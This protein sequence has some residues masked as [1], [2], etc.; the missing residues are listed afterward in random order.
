M[1]HGGCSR[2]MWAQRLWRHAG[3]QDG[4]GYDDSGAGVSRDDQRAGAPQEAGAAAQGARELIDA[5]VRRQHHRQEGDDN[6][7][8]R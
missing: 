3:D 8:L 2:G 4:H 1:G 6:L 5:I 7:R